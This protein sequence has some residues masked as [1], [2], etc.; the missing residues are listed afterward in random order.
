[1]SQRTCAFTGSLA[2]LG[3][4][5]C[6]CNTCLC[7]FNGNNAVP[8]GDGTCSPV[9]DLSSVT[10]S[11]S[12]MKETYQNSLNKYRHPFIYIYIYIYMV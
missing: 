5:E 4:A 7:D 9:S 11:N 12:D 3:D 10:P 1:M 2:S 8:A 6:G